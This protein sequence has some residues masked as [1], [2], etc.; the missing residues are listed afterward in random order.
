MISVQTRLKV[1]DNTGVREVMCFKV[2]GGSGRR[3]AYPGDVIVVSVK[4]ATPKSK[5]KAGS[6]CKAVVVR[7]K[8]GIVRKD[9]SQIAFDENAVVLI[10]N[11]EIIGTRISG[12]VPRELRQ[13]YMKIVSLAP[14]VY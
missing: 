2:L 13:K 11:D 14:E 9:G 12:P 7:T 4:E 1:A 10:K 5:I 6:V 8:K 3:F